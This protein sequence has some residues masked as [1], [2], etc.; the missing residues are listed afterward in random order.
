MAASGCMQSAVSSLW[1]SGRT[2][3]LV[4]RWSHYSGS[5]PDR[6]SSVCSTQPLTS[7]YGT[8]WKTTPSPWSQKGWILT[9]N[10]AQT[11]GMM[12]QRN[13]RFVVLICGAHVLLS[14][15]GDGHGCVRRLATTEHIFGDS[16]RTWV[17]KNRNAV[18]HKTFDWAHSCRRGEVGEFDDWSLLKHCILC[19]C[20]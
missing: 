4:N 13:C 17:R 6:Q 12:S 2:V 20:I 1:R 9:G 3:Q 7:T 16:T 19:G 10:V 15:Q 5:Q 8:C 14:S 18:F 11:W